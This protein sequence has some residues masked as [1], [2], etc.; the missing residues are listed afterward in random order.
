MQQTRIQ[1]FIHLFRTQQVKSQLY[2]DF[3]QL[4]IGSVMCILIFCILETIFYF[5]IPVRSGLVELFLLLF[6]SFLLYFLLRAYL[7]IKSIFNNC[8]NHSLARS[9]KHRAPF[10]GDRLLNAL[11]LEEALEEM[12]IG[13]DLAEYAVQ[14]INMELNTVPVSSLF[15]GGAFLFFFS[16]KIF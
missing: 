12:E 6:M 13:K 11:Q 14:K 4:T 10:I 2:R 3:I 1:T 8:S 9:F 15:S 5:T 7:N 16:K